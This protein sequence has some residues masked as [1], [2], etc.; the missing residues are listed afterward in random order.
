MER[1]FIIFFSLNI[2]ICSAASMNCD[3]EKSEIDVSVHVKIV[4]PHPEEMVLIT[5]RGASIWLMG[6]GVSNPV[7]E[8]NGFEDLAAF[9]L[10]AATTGTIWKDGK[11]VLIPILETPGEYELY[12]ADNVE[13]ERENALWMSCKFK[14]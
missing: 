8:I 2:S 4:V 10:T 5:P 9:T 3:V 11:E 13:T 7:Y 12:I 6:D 1:L 14:L